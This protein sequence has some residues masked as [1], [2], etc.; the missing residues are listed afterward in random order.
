M[1]LRSYGLPKKWLDEY[2]ISLVSEDPSESKMVN[3]TKDF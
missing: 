1:Y 2:V 3:G